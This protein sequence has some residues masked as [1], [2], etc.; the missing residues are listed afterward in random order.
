MT[1]I[2]L[3]IAGATGWTGSAIVDAVLAAP[4]IT[5]KSAVAR[6]SAGQD[7]GTALGRDALGVPVRRDV[8]EALDGVDVLV[9]FTS[10]DSAKQ[11][12]LQA[13]AHGVA[14]VMGS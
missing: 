14:V 3:A 11:I 7:L 1:N 6:S 10:H 4:D 13:I 5:L 12:V 8:G 9:E 2:N